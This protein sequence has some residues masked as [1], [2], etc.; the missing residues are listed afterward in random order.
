MD[1]PEFIYGPRMDK[2]CK[3][4]GPLHH[5]LVLSECRAALHVDEG[6]LERKKP[7]FICI[8]LTRHVRSNPLVTALRTLLGLPCA[9]NVR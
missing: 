6:P 9:S 8:S 3:S 5:Q 1:V 2:K 4:N 7:F